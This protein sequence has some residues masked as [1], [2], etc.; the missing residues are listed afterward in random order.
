MNFK[1]CC[2]FFYVIMDIFEIY[3]MFM[4]SFGFLC[5]FYGLVG[6]FKTDFNRL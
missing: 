4:I 5:I 2:E 6:S 1:D 3:G